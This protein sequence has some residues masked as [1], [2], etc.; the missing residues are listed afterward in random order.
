MSS[1]TT[2]TDID[3]GKRVVDQND[4]TIGRVV[5]VEDG[6][7]RVDPDPNMADSIRSKLGWGEHDEAE[8]RLDSDQVEEVTSDEVRIGSV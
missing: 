8:A 5:E 7:A 1:D 6:T 4:D 2:L 3:E